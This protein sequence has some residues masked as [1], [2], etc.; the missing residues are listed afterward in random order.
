MNIIWQ[1]IKWFSDGSHWSGDM[2]IPH[3][4]LEHVEVSAF[5]LVLATALALP[6][7]LLIG[8]TRRGEL[9]AVSIGNLGRVASREGRFDEALP[10]L[11]RSVELLRDVGDLAQ[12]FESETRIAELLLFESRWSV[13]LVTARQ[14]LVKS[15]GLEGVSPQVP[16]LHR[17]IGYA[18]AGLG[19]LDEAR[20]ALLNY[21]ASS[22]RSSVWAPR[23]IRSRRSAISASRFS[24][25]C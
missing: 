10:L 4:V 13:A 9:V 12:S 19:E 14:T 3:R 18:L 2:G 11:E 21:C 17:I 24:R 15:E 22:A 6:I 20:T 16:A 23:R 8:H 1:T 7:G 25:T 5:A